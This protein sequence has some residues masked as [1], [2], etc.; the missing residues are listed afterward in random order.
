[1]T[2]AIRDAG[3]GD[4]NRLTSCETSLEPSRA[5]RVEWGPGWGCR[6]GRGFRLPRLTVAHNSDRHFRFRDGT[7]Y[8]N[9]WNDRRMNLFGHDRR[10]GLTSPTAAKE[11]QDGAAIPGRTFLEKINKLEPRN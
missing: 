4:T 2:F 3:R 7:V 10:N 5:T 8:L 1:M 11:S 6:G 9:E